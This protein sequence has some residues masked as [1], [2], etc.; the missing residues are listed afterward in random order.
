MWTKE[1]DVTRPIRDDEPR[2]EPPSLPLSSIRLWR[3][4]KEQKHVSVR[5]EELKQLSTALRQ[6]EALR[7]TTCA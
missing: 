1:G 4:N 2:V 6:Q 5:G 3:Q 7:E